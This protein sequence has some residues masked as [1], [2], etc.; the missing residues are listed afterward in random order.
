MS[1]KSLVNVKGSDIRLAIFAASALLIVVGVG[2]SFGPGLAL[3]VA[4]LFGLAVAVAWAYLAVN[5]SA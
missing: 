2:V 1:G 3:I 5:P 4:G